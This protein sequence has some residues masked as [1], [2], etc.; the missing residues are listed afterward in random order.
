MQK[1]PHSLELTFI[2]H[3]HN[4]HPDRAGFIKVPLNIFG[5]S[6]GFVGVCARTTNTTTLADL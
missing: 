1:D 4:T 2:L 5:I 6:L 3:D